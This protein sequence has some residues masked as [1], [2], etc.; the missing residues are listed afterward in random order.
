[1]TIRVVHSNPIW[2]P[3]TQT[4]VHVQVSCVPSDRVENHVVCEHVENLDQFPVRHLH[5]FELAT[6]VERLWDRSLRRLGLRPYLGFLVRVAKAVRAD[7]IH[8]HFGDVGWRN[9]GA[10]R[11]AGTRHVVTF[12]GYDM[13]SLPRQ[14]LWRERFLDLFDKVDLILCEG[15]HMARCVVDIG[16]PEAK[17]RVHHLGV[18]LERLPFRPRQWR[19][20]EKL[21]VLIAA[22]FTEKK[23]IP[24]ALAALAR[25]QREV[26]LEIT[27]IGDAR[28][29][30]EE[31]RT[32]KEK[33]LAVIA[34]QGLADKV[35]LLGYQPHETLIAEAYDHH[36]FL[37]PSVTAQDGATEGGAPVSIVEM[38]ATGIF[39]VS[40]RHCDI[41]EVILDGETGF[42]ADE[43]DVIGL[44]DC[45]VR[46]V[47]GPEKWPAMLAAG[48]RH[49]ERE[50]NAE[51][52]GVRLS[53]LYEG[54]VG[55]GIGEK[56]LNG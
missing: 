6:R 3:Q 16:S 10:A 40:T 46:A 18:R 1:M 53:A 19:P 8:S 24:Y 42:L 22:T 54:T 23:G 36:V 25:L 2:L 39:I 37:S 44:H 27:V 4:W 21:R 15:P 35:R 5:S 9:I 26:D 17:V 14:A 47:R 29:E 12:Y 13:S 38:A 43:R 51:V 45:L 30:V 50:F 31:S 33:I 56:R 48:R 32:Q 28:P 55:G 11:A 7:I 52:Q 49:I 34:G 20:G 41:P